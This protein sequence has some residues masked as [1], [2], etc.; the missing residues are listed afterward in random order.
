MYLELP[1]MRYNLHSKKPTIILA[2]KHDIT[3]I[4]NT[5]RDAELK[6][7]AALEQL[8]ISVGMFSI[9]DHEPQEANLQALLERALFSN[10][11][12]TG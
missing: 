4:L 3:Y 9:I 1:E 6:S 11:S 12:D 10:L 7:F 8:A 2:S 5:W